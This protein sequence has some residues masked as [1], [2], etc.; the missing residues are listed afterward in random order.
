M[1]DRGGH[2]LIDPNNIEIVDSQPPCSD[3]DGCMEDLDGAF[4]P[5]RRNNPFFIANRGPTIAPSV[6][7]SLIT[8]SQIAEAL[9]EGFNVTITTETIGDIPGDQDGNITV[10]GAIEVD[11]RSASE[12]ESATLTLR[13]ANDLTINANIG[14]YDAPADITPGTTTGSNLTLNLLLEA[15]DF[16]QP[17]NPTSGSEVDNLFVG[18]LTLGADIKTEGGS[19]TLEGVDIMLES[20]SSIV[21]NGGGVGIEAL[22][23]DITLAGDIDTSSIVIINDKG[24]TRDAGIIGATATAILRPIDSTA[25][26][27]EAVFG[28]NIVVSG[29]LDAGDADIELAANGGDLELDP[30]ARL[31]T[32]GGSLLLSSLA[33]D[34]GTGPAPLVT[35]GTVSIGRDVVIRSNGGFVDVGSTTNSDLGLGASDIVMRGEIDTRVYEADG[36]TVDEDARGG[37]VAF[38]TVDPDGGV[39][40]QRDG[41]NASD[42]PQ[43][44]TNGGTF[45]SRGPGTF[46][47]RDAVID[48][49]QAGADVE[50][51]ATRLDLLINHGQAVTIEST[52]AGVT[53]LY[54]DSAIQL[55]AGTQTGLDDLTLRGGI[56]AQADAFI[57]VAGDGYT[58]DEGTLSS[59]VFETLGGSA[60]P[61]FGGFRNATTASGP[62]QFELSQDAS[63]DA[64]PVIARIN[65][66]S[67]LERL[68][69]ASR[70]GDL[71]A[72][73][74]LAPGTGLNSPDLQVLLRAARDIHVDAGFITGPIEQLALEVYEDFTVDA[75]LAG[76]ISQDAGTLI[77]RSGIVERAQSDGTVL[78]GVGDLIIEGDLSARDGLTLHAGHG[79]AGDLHFDLDSGDAD[80][81]LTLG[82]KNL[83]L[84]AGNGDGTGDSE[85]DASELRDVAFNLNP[86][87]APD[88]ATARFTLQQDAA[89]DDDLVPDASQFVD[90]G[91]SAVGVVGLDYRLRS[92]A[93]GIRLAARSAGQLTDTQLR[94]H[95]E[96][97]IV[98]DAAL[99]VQSMDIGGLDNFEYEHAQ[100]DRISF[101]D[102]N[103]SKLVVRA[104]LRESGILTFES[105]MVIEA[106]EIRLVASDDV[107][108]NGSPSGPTGSRI[109]IDQNTDGYEAP[110]FRALTDP[111]ALTFVFRQ[112]QL[113]RQSDLP[114]LFESFDGNRPDVYA[115]RSDDDD[116][117]FSTFGGA[118]APSANSRLILSAG[119][120]ELLRT[121][122]LDLD[123]DDAFDLSDGGG[124]PMLA[125]ILDVRT[126]WLALFARGS[127]FDTAPAVLPGANV[128][129]SGLDVSSA[130]ELEAAGLPIELDLANAPTTS[131]GVIEIEQ[132]ASI[133]SANLIALCQ[134]GG[135]PLACGAPGPPAPTD[136]RAINRY[137]LTSHR[138]NITVTPDDVTGADLEMFL[139][140]DESE[141]A[142]SVFFDTNGAD[143]D[144][145]S[146]LIQSDFGLHIGG[147]LTQDQALRI[148]TGPQVIDADTNTG[149]GRIDV[150]AGQSG[151][152]DLTFTDQAV[153]EFEA[154]AIQLLAGT[155]SLSV[156]PAI[157]N[158]PLP[159][160][161]V[162]DLT[163]FIF[164]DDPDGNVRTSFDIAQWGSLTDDP[165]QAGRAGVSVL[166]NASN[167]YYQAYDASGAPTGAPDP[168][169]TID[170]IGLE[171]QYGSLEIRDL[172]SAGGQ[173]TLPARNLELR[174][175]AGRS[176]GSLISLGQSDGQDLDLRLFDTVLMAAQEIELS[177]VG[178][179]YV[180]A[181]GSGIFFSGDNEAEPTSPTRFRVTQ[182]AG[183][184]ERLEIGGMPQIKCD[185][186][187]LPSAFQFLGT[188]TG[189]DYTIES[190][191]G[192]IL[193]DDIM[194]GKL[195]GGNVTLLADAPTGPDVH[196]DVVSS[197]LFDA[198]FTSL[199]VGTEGVDEAQLDI[200]LTGQND[201]DDAQFTLIS[202]TDIDFYG[203][204]FVDGDVQLTANVIDYSSTIDAAA[205]PTTGYSRLTNRAIEQVRFDGDIGSTTALDLLNTEFL[206][207]GDASPTARFGNDDVDP[208][209]VHA[210]QVKF[211]AVTT[212]F[213][214]LTI[215]QETTRLSTAATIFRRE[216]DLSFFTN[217]FEMGTGEKLSVG[218]AVDIQASDRATLGDVSALDISV[219]APTIEIALRAGGQYRLQDGSLRRDAGVSFVANTI[220]FSG[221]VIGTGG[222]ERPVFGIADPRS[223]PDWMDAYSVFGINAA[224]R[225]L[226]VA[227]F[228]W[229]Y[230][231]TT[232]PDLHPQGGSRDDFS[233]VF[234][235][236]D[237]TP[238]PPPR[239]YEGWIPWNEGPLQELEIAARP[240]TAAEYAS[241]LSGAGIFDDVGRDLAQWDRRPL[242]IAE[243]R[244]TG[245]EAE[246]AVELFNELFGAD[247][248]RA[249]GLRRILQN[250]IDQYRYTTGAS[251]V[252]GF[253]LRRYVKNRPSSR[254]E[255]Y[256]ALED[257]DRLF[258]YH[259]RLGLTPGE[260][261]PIQKSWLEA[262]QPEGISVEELAEAIRPSR[263]V[264]GTDVL[265]IFGE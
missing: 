187:C 2:W 77:L 260:Y 194:A 103:T 265:D 117:S 32:Y 256:R 191:S 99:R 202:A 254:F 203:N 185:A 159:V 171:S 53:Q 175:G 37:A 236:P 232:I 108:G 163:R 69:L 186:G 264:R 25:N 102:P 245:Q 165:T 107:G 41:T 12:G 78:G 262:I 221:N 180:M 147:G 244:L 54:A 1:G 68:G 123:L 4:D 143:Y 212:D 142:R 50:P 157:T 158:P 86:G 44:R 18:T 9:A 190:R 48:V 97:Q 112:D 58:P 233:A 71:T 80:G 153:V 27:P 154:T 239:D 38:T 155:G 70:D 257:L 51:D 261:R 93:G 76:T 152:G 198:F 167:F 79:G 126:E 184:D 127:G 174:A 177:A 42:N 61:T 253:E 226:T 188:P 116:L 148:R 64:A 36:T 125:S 242:Q 92:D 241:R 139:L 114:D 189:L 246:A 49:T 87:A 133:G 101:T 57:L 216:G 83:A 237:V 96:Q 150:F 23:G 141:G 14:V 105:G 109:T 26:S 249:R 132:D 121:D 238:R 136:P 33:I 65:T 220:D 30:G 144:L 151:E 164:A 113:V 19:V 40:I 193:F 28:G 100:N 146:L 229:N 98:L 137:L 56:D 230:T 156:P 195:W 131:P 252:V 215:S 104:G 3:P 29:N 160:V 45:S 258:T 119:L 181:E 20:G 115:I 60:L 5:D 63:L 7:D 196:F 209:E 247:G 199:T 46:Y 88:N 129:V 178:A 243:N 135:S 168:N 179:G 13:A 73:A 10:S 62:T 111:R 228:A 234:V 52:T 140:G 192:G 227:D 84:R 205:A 134:L 172:F 75:T 201:P 208:I 110:I 74:P 72:S 149:P 21:T 217:Q 66:P 138:G 222:G 122:G 197:R 94:L 91:G 170:V 161:R 259:R 204:V 15:G 176:A 223:A 162:S 211:I 22:A 34:N 207:I 166:P 145:A 200:L 224:R 128:R 24:D 248:S 59:V 235:G 255:A 120:V 213:E 11:D 214:S 43:I 106:D 89:I 67:D 124:D 183:F 182:D 225:P 35:G 8:A 169:A 85:I 16:D 263:Y 90:D 130:E 251:R 250:A 95:A 81:V 31:S 173:S 240:G 231:T 6:N 118:D 55:A 82:S 47:L 39:V 218:G 219:T 17:Q 210:G 206:L